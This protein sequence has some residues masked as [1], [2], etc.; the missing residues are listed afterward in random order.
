MK[1][2]PRKP[3]EPSWLE[4]AAMAHARDS[5]AAVRQCNVLELDNP[6][7]FAPAALQEMLQRMLKTLADWDPRNAARVVELALRGGLEP[8]DKA[9]RE[10][11]AERNERGEP[12][13]TAL[14]TYSNILAD[15]GGVITYRQPH[16]RP[17][18]S[19][20]AAFVIVVLIFDL[21]CTFPELRLRRSSPK[22]P[23]ACSIWS[24]VLAEAGIGRGRNEEAIRKIW[25]Q[26][27]PPVMQAPA[28]TNRTKEAEFLRALATP[29]R[30][31][32]KIPSGDLFPTE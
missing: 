32:K 24:A 7:P 28:S 5:L 21:M 18:E 31:L 29:R 26:Y 10:L 20:L 11:I 23:S 15:R 22:H 4:V 2:H 14:V 27:G 16:S 3:D 12:L 1:K 8:A 19:P 9:L 25:D 17:R 13:S 6:D 30:E